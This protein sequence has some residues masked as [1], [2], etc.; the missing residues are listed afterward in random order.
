MASYQELILK[1]ERYASTFDKGNLPLPPSKKLVVVT[2]MDARI[3]P[4]AQLQIN[5]GEAHVIR[6]AGGSAKEALRSIVISQRLLGTTEVAVFHHTNCGMLTFTNDDIRQKVKAEEPG[7]IAVAEAIDK[8]DFLTFPNLKE[9]VQ[10]DIHYLKESKLLK[11]G[12]H[13]SGWIY[14]VTTGKISLDRTCN[15]TRNCLVTITC[16]CILKNVYRLI[17][18]ATLPCCTTVNLNGRAIPD[19]S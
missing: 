12:T 14:D 16:I 3:D 17:L 7:N 6:N 11:E 8:I 2:C 9:S 4:A 19:L 18:E 13:L 5:L 10:D 1:N 15:R